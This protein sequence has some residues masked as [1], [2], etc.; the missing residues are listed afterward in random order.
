MAELLFRAWADPRAEVDVHSAGM[1]ALSGR[2]IDASSA[3]AL[4]QLGIDTSQHR[5]KQFEPWMATQSHVILTAERAHRD[6]LM[7]DQPAIFRRTFTMKEFTR[8]APFVDA[9]DAT[10]AVAQASLQRSQIGS[11]PEEEDDVADPF[12]SAVK[13][14]KT[15]AEEITDNV[16]AT[17]DMLRFSPRYVSAGRPMPYRV[18]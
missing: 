17:L 11:V 7:T 14:A 8:L 15:I 12:K 5:A 18:P 13:R 16:R 10:A 3:S 2:A 4:G 6:K 1:E 9:S